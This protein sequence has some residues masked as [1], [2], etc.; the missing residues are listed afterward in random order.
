MHIST[1]RFSLMV[2][3]DMNMSKSLLCLIEQNMGQEN[4]EADTH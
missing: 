1:V 3:S 2:E 4:H